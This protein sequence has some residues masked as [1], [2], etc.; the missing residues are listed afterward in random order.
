V[1]AGTLAAQ[2]FP[3]SCLMF[4][5]TETSILS[6]PEYAMET[7]SEIKIEKSFVMDM[8]DNESDLVIVRTTI[9]LAHN[10][11]RKVVAEGVE[12]PKILKALHTMGCD[13]AQ[14][15]YISRPLSA[16]EFESWLARRAGDENAAA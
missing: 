12:T 8:L 3:P 10:L 13:V 15:Y 9:D 11:A 16:S 7:I 5:I 1:V 2:P 6:D 4:E 14:G